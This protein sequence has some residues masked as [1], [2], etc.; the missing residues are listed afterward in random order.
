MG[1]RDPHGRYRPRLR[2]VPVIRSAPPDRSGGVFS[3]IRMS[4]S[5]TRLQRLR[6]WLFVIVAL[7]LAGAWFLWKALTEA[8]TPKGLLG[9]TLHYYEDNQHLDPFRFQATSPDTRLFNVEVTEARKALDTCKIND[10]VMLGASDQPYS[11]SS[12]YYKWECQVEDITIRANEMWE[13]HLGIGGI[14]FAACINQNC[15]SFEQS[16]P[17]TYK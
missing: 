9:M 10:W 16:F 15:P 8:S 4:T 5:K 7:G 14:T 11:D 13:P 1:L 12:L 3:K 2:Q 17:D 6:P